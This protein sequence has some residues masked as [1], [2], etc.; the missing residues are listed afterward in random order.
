MSFQSALTGH[1]GDGIALAEAAQDSI[2]NAGVPRVKA[3]IASRE[4]GAHAKAGNH[5]ECVNALG[6]AE[7][8]LEAAGGSST[9]PGALGPGP[10]RPA[11]SPNLGSC[12]N[13]N[14]SRSSPARTGDS[15][16][17]SRVS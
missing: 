13:S 4:A 9:D 7:R 3:M 15:G 6:R 8:Y 2:K 11:P 16:E 17:R 10:G 12:R 1:P 14:E 5:R